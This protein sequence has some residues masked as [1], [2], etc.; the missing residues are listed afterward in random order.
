MKKE[1]KDR[2]VCDRALDRPHLECVVLFLLL[3]PYY[4][5]GEHLVAIRAEVDD[6]TKKNSYCLKTYYNVLFLLHFFFFYLFLAYRPRPE[7]TM[8]CLSSCNTTETNG[9]KSV[10]RRI[11]I[12]KK[13][14]WLKI[15]INFL[16]LVPLHTYIHIFFTYFFVFS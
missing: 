9:L 4:Y 6:M 13:I 12:I 7:Y 14:D 15:R 8:P 2:T 3:S 1:Q 11:I 10:Q 5:D 16:F